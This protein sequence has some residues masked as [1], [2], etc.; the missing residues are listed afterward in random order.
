M[1][2]TGETGLASWSK[3]ARELHGDF[4]IAPS[5]R[6]AGSIAQRTTPAFHVTRC[7]SS[8]VRITRA[9]AH[10][11]SNPTGAFEIKLIRRGTCTVTTRNGSQTFTSG[12]LLG[13]RLDEPA[14]LE[15]SPGFAAAYLTIR[16]PGVLNRMLRPHAWTSPTAA[17]AI[18][19][20]TIAALADHAHELSV[21]QFDSSCRYVS[22]LLADT[23]G[24]ISTE[25][26]LAQLVRDDVSIHFADPDLTTAQIARRLGWSPRRVQH[27]M[28]REGTT[29]TALIR[30]ERLE[31]AR[32]VLHDTTTNSVSIAQIG[33]D[34]GFA[35]PSAF[36]AAF[37]EHFGRT[38]SQARR[39]AMHARPM[40]S[41][42]A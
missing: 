24:E 13:Y 40:R 25:A 21:T 31:R 14:V 12:S 38:P 34:H 27:E 9:E 11:S 7:A 16:R 32:T 20:R 18:A 42:E 15:H 10:I 8:R 5:E 3:R 28:Q 23:D 36:T 37:H 6:F 29:V 1:I 17:L 41:E 33:R 22:G 26:T 35:S 19:S 2:H 4:D 39:D 30:S